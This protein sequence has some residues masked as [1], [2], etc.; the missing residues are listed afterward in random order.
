MRLSER[1]QRGC[2]PGGAHVAGLRLT[3]PPVDYLR[4]ERNVGRLEE[5]ATRTLQKVASQARPHTLTES[6]ALIFLIR[7]RVASG[8]FRHLE[9]LRAVPDF[10]VYWPESWKRRGKKK[11]KRRGSD[12][13][14]AYACGGIG[15]LRL[16]R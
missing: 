5:H 9:D 11:S 4:R 16:Y 7:C 3:M 13:C 12:T 1:L 8:S 6:H 14:S 10:G 15:S 2:H